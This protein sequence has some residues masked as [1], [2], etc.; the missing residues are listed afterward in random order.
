MNKQNFLC[1]GCGTRVEPG[2]IVIH[3]TLISILQNWLILFGH[4]QSYNEHVS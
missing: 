2:K 1:A 3:F 4:L